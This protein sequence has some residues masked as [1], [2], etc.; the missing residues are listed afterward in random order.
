MA[1]WIINSST[2]YFAVLVERMKQELLKLPVT[3]SDETPTQVIRDDRGPGS[4]SYMWV[5]RSGEFFMERPIVIYEYQKGRNHELPLA[6]YQ[7]YKGV[8]VTDGLKQY[9]LLQDKI[10]RANKCELLS[11][12]KKG[13]C[14]CHQSRKQNRWRSSKTVNRLSGFEPYC[15]DI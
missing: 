9:H 8:L 15:I 14:R 13:L 6:F 10:P 3:Q 5:H 4:K 7:D 11:S 2:R 1:N 12:R